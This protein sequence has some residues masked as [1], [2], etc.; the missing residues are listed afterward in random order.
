M[1]RRRELMEKEQLSFT[2]TEFFPRKCF[3][4]R[5]VDEGGRKKKQMI[6]MREGK[7]S[8]DPK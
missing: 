2:G 8:N 1:R 3:L 7:E 4:K 5:E 6:G